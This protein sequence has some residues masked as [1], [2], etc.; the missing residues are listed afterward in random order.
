MNRI[1]RATVKDKG[2]TMKKPRTVVASGY[3]IFQPKLGQPRTSNAVRLKLSHGTSR[4]KNSIF[5]RMAP[6][7]SPRR[8]TE[9]LIKKT[10]KP[11]DEAVRHILNMY[12]KKTISA[13]SLY[14]N[15][16]QFSAVIN[17][18]KSLSKSPQKYSPVSA[19]TR[20]KDPAR[21][22]VLK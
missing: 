15:K 19:H 11:T 7:I 22:S 21:K 16:N 10:G 1:K 20:S 3:R 18:L 8:L 2:K 6:N 12:T 13:Q 9:H 14:M 4:I 17:T 5:A